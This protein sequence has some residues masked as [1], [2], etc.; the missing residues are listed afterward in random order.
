[1]SRARPVLPGRTYLITRRTTQRLFLLKPSQEVNRVF[2]Y[3]LAVAAERFSVRVHAYCV[4]SNHYHL[5]VT[6]SEAQLP[7][8]MQWLGCMLARCLNSHRSRWEN[9]WASGTYSRVELTAD[10]DVL[11]KMSYTLANP[12]TSGLVAHSGDWPGVRSGTLREG[13]ETMTVKRPSFFFRKKGCLPAEAHLLVVRPGGF[14]QLDDRAFAE[15]LEGAV[16]LREEA[17]REELRAK[18]KNFIGRV[19]V[20]KQSPSDRPHAREPRRGM[21]P[22]VAAKDK[23]RR[24]ERLEWLRSWLEAYAEA[25]KRFTAGFREVIFPA[26]TYWMRVQYGVRCHAPP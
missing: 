26:G 4:L 24:I 15:A 5:V 2:R 11:S 13:A 6:D 14:L 8:F 22:R 9:F 23:W 3:C 20:L 25:L 16:K 19:K 17:V 1:M 10:E 21:N 18:G 7:R 12:V